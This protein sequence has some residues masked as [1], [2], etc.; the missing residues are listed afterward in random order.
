MGNKKI[1]D[2][3]IFQR[4]DD[5]AGLSYIESPLDFFIMLARYK[6]AIRFLK[7]S[8]AV[9]DAGCG[10]GYGSIFLSKYAKNV[11]GVDYDKNQMA[12]NNQR[13]AFIKNLN[14]KPINLLNLTHF[15]D[16]YDALVSMDVIEHFKKKDT[17]I[18]A[19]NYAKLLKKNG[20]AIIGT[21][22]K[23]SQPFA[24]ARRLAIHLH[25][26]EPEEFK[27]LLSK[28]FRQVFLFSMNDEIVS[29]SF[30]KMAWYLM[31]LCVK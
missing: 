30:P 28:H 2:M 16:R 22:N 11:T 4:L 7:K 10:Y 19:K 24:S 13:Y 26:F 3:D 15:K 27:D 20:F 5:K 12:E 6:F 25:E 18:V 9:L 1:L 8:H 31:A 29:Q 14:F 21:P 23:Y 17:E